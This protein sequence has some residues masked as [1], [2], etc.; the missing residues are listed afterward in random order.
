[1]TGSA[2]LLADGFRSG[3]EAVR[4]Y[5]ARAA[6]R[7]S[8]GRRQGQLQG[9]ASGMLAP[10]L[11]AGMLMLVVGI[12]LCLANVR[13]LA[14][15]TADVP[16]GYAAAII[17]GLW[18]VR[19]LLLPDRR[20]ADTIC[21]AIA[22]AGTGAAIVSD[23]VGGPLLAHADECA[24][25]GIG[26][27]LTMEGYRQIAGS[28]AGGSY[29][30]LRSGV[31][32][33]LSE[34]V[35]RVDGVIAIEALHAREQGHYVAVELTISVN[36]RITIAE[37]QEIARRVK[38]RLMDAFTHVTEVQ[39]RVDPYDPGYPYKSNHDPNQDHMPTLLQ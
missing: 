33:E 28:L 11:L 5:A 12:E 32:A 3:S 25:I 24:A 35:Q 16:N 10:N 39:V 13:D 23:R 20:S 6:A 26:V 34:A 29:A 15:G 31:A 2:A 27:F 36:P 21:S 14:A 4:W 18:L 17:L 1:M 9:L 38:D 8:G 19:A 7:G 22:L 37:G 30:G